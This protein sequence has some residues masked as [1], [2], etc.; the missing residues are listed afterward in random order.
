M[1]DVA[2]WTLASMSWWYRRFLIKRRRYATSF[3]RVNQVFFLFSILTV[4]II[5]IVVFYVFKGGLLWL[6]VEMTGLD[7]Y[8]FRE[9]GK[10]CTIFDFEN[11]A[12]VNPLDAVF[13]LAWHPLEDM[14]VSWWNRACERN[15][16]IIF[17]K[18]EVTGMSL[19]DGLFVYDN[20]GI[21]PGIQAVIFD[22][23]SSVR[24]SKLPL[25]A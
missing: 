7:F 20:H 16:V 3:G 10:C 11:C 17:L 22:V 4:W 23:V 13:I 24:Y 5:P 14:T 25:S 15:D 6:K 9:R 8:C 12:L 19:D 21:L 2:F 1:A 18:S